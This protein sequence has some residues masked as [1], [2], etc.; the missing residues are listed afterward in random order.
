MPKDTSV[1][2]LPTRHLGKGYLLSTGG[3]TYML[4]LSTSL[5]SGTDLDRQEGVLIVPRYK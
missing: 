1:R 2:Q 5:N 4:F 3:V